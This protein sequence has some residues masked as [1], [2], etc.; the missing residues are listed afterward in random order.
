MKSKTFLSIF[1]LVSLFFSCTENQQSIAQISQE[2]WGNLPNGQQVDL[3][4]LTNP[5]GMTVKISNFG[6]TIVSW[7]AADKAG[8]YE[9]I[10]LGCD[11]LSGYLKGTPYFGALVG[12]YGNRIAK[13]KF[14]LDGQRYTLP[15]NNGENALHGG[16]KGF[17]KVIWNAKAIEGDEPKL[18]LN[19][20]S[21]DGEE[22]FPGNLKVQVVYT[23]K[24]NDALEITYTATTDKKTV[25]NLTNHA[26]FNL[27]GNFKL[28]ILDHELTLKADKFLPIDK[29]LIPTGVLKSVKDSPFDFTK[30]HRIGERINLK[31]T[32]LEYGKG[33]DHCWIAKDT[34]SIHSI[35]E[36]YEPNSGRFMEVLTSEPA[37]QFYTGN[38]LN[39]TVKGKSGITYQQ[40]TGFCLETEHFP[41]SPNR[42]KFPTTELKPGE[43]Y[44]STTIY[45]FSVL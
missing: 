13:G 40:R 10:T 15:I 7:T 14:T 4:T 38:F 26:Y 34:S 44:R 43:V 6:G 25:I 17:D 11:S 30:A 8:N 3:Y 18:V 37:V 29:G 42:S 35:A 45:K 1:V 12:R 39:G 32:Q 16:L 21:K 31:D 2:P 19:Y 22:G 36:V 5:N 20:L 24:K 27:S 9:D 41:D 28:P 33:Y 23:L